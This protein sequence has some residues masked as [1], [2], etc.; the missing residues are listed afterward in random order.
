MGDTKKSKAGSSVSRKTKQCYRIADNGKFE[1]RNF[2]TDGMQS[3]ESLGVCVCVKS[4]GS[5][6][7]LKGRSGHY[8]A[9]PGTRNQRESS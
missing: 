9:N 3:P 8:R 2:R 7:R 5:R 4:E 1:E 6:G